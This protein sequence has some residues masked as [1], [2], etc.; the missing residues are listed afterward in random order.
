MM[1]HKIHGF[2]TALILSVVSF[3]VIFFFCPDFS[4]K[5]LGISFKDRKKIE[6]KAEKVSSAAEDAVNEIIDISTL[7]KK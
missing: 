4:D 7:L 5:Y 3:F 1:K 2:L 6:A